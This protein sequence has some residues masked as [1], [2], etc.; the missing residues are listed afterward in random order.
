[1][2]IEVPLFQETSPALKSFALQICVS[3]L[4]SI[5]K[6]CYSK[7]ASNETKKETLVPHGLSSHIYLVKKM[8]LINGFTI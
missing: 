6:Q 4:F 7:L 5:I 2:S 8:I 3:I 1:M